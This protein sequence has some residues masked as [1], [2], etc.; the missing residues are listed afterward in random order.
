MKILLLL[1]KSLIKKNKF[2][3]NRSQRRSNSTEAIL[4]MKMMK[5]R[6]LSRKRQ[7]REVRL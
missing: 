1:K 2:K 4:I 6:E 3:Q 7:I 5:N